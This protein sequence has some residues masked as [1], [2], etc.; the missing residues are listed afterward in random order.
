MVPD[1]GPFPGGSPSSKVPNE[2]AH[3]PALARKFR[4][5]PTSTPVVAQEVIIS[6]TGIGIANNQRC[7]ESLAVGE[8]N[9]FRRPVFNKNFICYGLLVDLPALGTYNCG[10]GISNLLHPAHGV[11]HS[12]SF[13]QMRN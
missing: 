13:F 10:H 5:R 11:M 4:C 9:R 12:I 8:R 2:Q 7:I 3:R 6:V 1:I